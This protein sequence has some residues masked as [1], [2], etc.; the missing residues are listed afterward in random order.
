[1]VPLRAPLKKVKVDA[2]PNTDAA[3][4]EALKPIRGADNRR[5][6]YLDRQER[7]RL[8]AEMESAATTFFRAACM[9]PLRPGALAALKVSDLDKKTRPLTIGADK[10]GNLRQIALPDNVIKFL[11]EAA[12]G[13]LPGVWLFSTAD[14]KQWTRKKWQ[15]PMKEARERANLTSG[16]TRLRTSALRPHGSRHG[17][18]PVSYDCSTGRHVGSNDRTTLWPP[19]GEGCA[20]CARSSGDLVK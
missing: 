8:L 9:L 3:W 17:G 12:A 18:C 11:S 14:G 4:Q 1:M 19:N 15:E 2:A 16:T 5:M 20:R 6:I 10:S 13:K 7:Q